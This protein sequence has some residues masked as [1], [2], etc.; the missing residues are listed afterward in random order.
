M[1][2]GYFNMP[3][4]N[5]LVKKNRQ[6]K[7]KKSKSPVLNVGFNTLERKQTNATKH[8]KD[9]SNSSKAIDAHISD[10][11]GTTIDKK[12]VKF[13]QRSGKNDTSPCN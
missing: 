4:I 8:E 11:T 2:G 6:K 9:A 3:T 5:Q 1:E 12:L 10:F 7:T 13:I